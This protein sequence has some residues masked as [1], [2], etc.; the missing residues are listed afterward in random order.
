[1][2]NRREEAIAALAVHRLSC[3]KCGGIHLEGPR[4]T[5]TIDLLE[6]LLE[7]CWSIQGR[8][9]PD[10]GPNDRIIEYRDPTGM[11]G[12]DYRAKRLDEFPKPVAEWIVDNV[13][14]VSVKDCP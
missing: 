13:C 8:R 1:M 4:M 10:G 3:Q 7:R 2:G 11:S 9:D 6:A 14:L 5:V 12:W